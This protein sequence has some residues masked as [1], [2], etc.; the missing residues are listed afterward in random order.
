MTEQLEST[1]SVEKTARAKPQFWA[2]V[3][4]P[5]GESLKPLVIKESSRKLLEQALAG[6]N[7]DDV[8][9]AFR[10]KVHALTAQSKVTF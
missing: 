1:P 8:I 10:G 4:N 6:R 3:T 9:W 5:A 2:V 7:A